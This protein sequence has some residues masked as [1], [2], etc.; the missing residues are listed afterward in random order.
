MVSKYKSCCMVNGA[1]AQCDDNNN[2]DSRVSSCMLRN[3][4]CIFESQTDTLRLQAQHL[5]G[6]FPTASLSH[7]TAGAVSMCVGLH[8]RPKGHCVT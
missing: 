8:A 1:I 3:V 2:T 4:K 5:T 6:W 7:V